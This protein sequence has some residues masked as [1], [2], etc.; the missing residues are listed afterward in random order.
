[1]II[2]AQFLTGQ[3]FLDFDILKKIQKRHYQVTPPPPPKKK[4]NVQRQNNV[5]KDKIDL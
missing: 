2:K 5:V 3:H 1:M 4:E